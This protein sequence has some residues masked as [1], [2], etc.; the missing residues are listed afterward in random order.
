[1][2]GAQKLD[3]I[4]AQRQ[5]ETVKIE[6]QSIR[7]L[8]SDLSLSHNIPIAVEVAL[9]DDESA[10]YRLNGIKTTLSHLLTAFVTEHSEYSWQIKDGVISERFRSSWDMRQ[11]NWSGNRLPPSHS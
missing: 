6:A 2:I 9:N 5:L 8:F 4:L 3:R 11:S 10:I 1:V 7:Q